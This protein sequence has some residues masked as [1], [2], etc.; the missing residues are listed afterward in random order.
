MGLV[1]F[2]ISW[3]TGESFKPIS[4][5][6]NHNRAIIFDCHLRTSLQSNAK[7]K[8]LQKYH[9]HDQNPNLILSN[10]MPVSRGSVVPFEWNSNGVKMLLLKAIKIKKTNVN[11]FFRK[12][13]VNF[14]GQ[15]WY[16]IKKLP[17]KCSMNSFSLAKFI[18]YY[19]FGNEECCCF[20]IKFY[21]SFFN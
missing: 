18:R 4:K 10:Y 2:V 5:R 1:L 21:V 3:K 7:A 13:F 15:S 6:R 9:I 16:P 14:C 8:W 11:V 20:G 12:N 17:Q 19:L